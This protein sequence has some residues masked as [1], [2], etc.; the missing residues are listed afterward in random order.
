MLAKCILHNIPKDIVSL[1][2]QVFNQ[3]LCNISVLLLVYFSGVTIILTEIASIYL[4]A[5]ISASRKLLVFLPSLCYVSNISSLSYIKMSITFRK[6][7][8]VI[9]LIIIASHIHRF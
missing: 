7:K 5:A 9:L 2:I 1:H 3:Y 8:I 6:W 4:E